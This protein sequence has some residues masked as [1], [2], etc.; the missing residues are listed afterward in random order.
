MRE[1]ARGLLAASVAAVSAAPGAADARAHFVQLS[2]VLSYSNNS[3]Q[4]S[5]GNITSSTATWSYDDV[6]GL[7]TQV[8][9][10]FNSR[11]TTA[12]TT[13]LFR[14]SITGLV[15]GAGGPASAATYVCTE[16]N[17]GGNVGASLCGNYSLGAN[18]V[19]DSTASWGP[20]TAVSRTLGRDDVATGD[21]QSIGLLD[22]MYDSGFAGAGNLVLTNKTCTGSCTT[23]PVGAFNGGQQWTFTGYWFPI[24]W[25]SPSPFHFTD[26]SGVPLASTITSAPIIISGLLVPATRIFTNSGQYS[27]DGGAFTSVEGYVSNGSSVRVRHSSASVPGTSVSTR[28]AVG[29]EDDYFTSTTVKYAVEDAVT[30]LTDQAV[31]ID[32]LAND[33]DLAASVEV[34]IQSGPQ[35]GTA[36][37][38]GA[39]GAPSGIRITYTPNPGYLGTDGLTYRLQNGEVVDEGLV[40]VQVREPDPD[41]DGLLSTVDNCTDVANTAQCDSDGD[42][43]GNRC[44]ADFN[45]NI[46]TNAQDTTV[47]RTQLGKP[48]AAPFFNAADFNCNGAVNAQDT[49]IMR[50][51]LGKPPGPSGQN[52]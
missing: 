2:Q 39:P 22:G 19:N 21:P 49:T 7:L 18:F 28:L 6:T 32:V 50:G 20:G 48:S 38:T 40:R 46:A 24:E 37:V 26:Q 1:H 3:T 12:P 42:G 29:N 51:L 9:G 14:T 27:I 13:T 25:Y 47:F 5:A 16:G 23:L 34:L 41:G 52:P 10:L 17:F 15:I 36:L 31:E 35:H 11:V 43:Y 45:N 44:D 30:T 33:N 8:G 4:G